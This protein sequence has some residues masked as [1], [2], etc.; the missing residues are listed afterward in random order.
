MRDF[1]I[2]PALGFLADDQNPSTTLHKL[3]VRLTKVSAP[4]ILKSSRHH[5]EM[6]RE[7][8]SENWE[9]SKCLQFWL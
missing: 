4:M 9:H 3:H 7:E 1:V 6:D 2:L 8:R 5:V